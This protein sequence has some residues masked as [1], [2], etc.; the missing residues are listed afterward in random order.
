MARV[1]EINQASCVTGG[2]PGISAC[3]GVAFDQD[4][5]RGSAGGTNA[6]DTGLIE[7][8]DERLIHI[9]IFVVCVKY[10]GGVGFEAR[11]KGLAECS[12]AVN[13]LVDEWEARRSKDNLR[14]VI[15]HNIAIISA[16]IVR[17]D[18]CEP[19]TR[20]Y[21]VHCRDQSSQVFARK[22]SSQPA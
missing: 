15:C 16:I 7:V 17:V 18:D 2:N 6:V 1:G 22:H 19:S 8:E 14:S 3:I 20:G 9:V 4:E 11:G 12:E 10:D 21:V 13:I 5:L